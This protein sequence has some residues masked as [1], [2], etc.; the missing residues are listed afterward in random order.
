MLDNV[1]VPKFSQR[2]DQT[3]FIST[4]E[5]FYGKLSGLEKNRPTA[6]LWVQN[7]HM[8]SIMKQYIIIDDDF[9]NVNF[10]QKN[11]EVHFK[12]HNSKV[13]IHGEDI[14][15]NTYTFPTHKTS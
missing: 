4:M 1:E 13:R 11:R 2:P 9:S 5:N 12:A 8:V 7:F 3:A 10:Q 6:K 14:Q 15:V